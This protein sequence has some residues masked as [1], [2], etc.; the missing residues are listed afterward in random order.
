MRLLKYGAAFILVLVTV[1]AFAWTTG[2][3]ILGQWSDGQWYP[4]RITGMEGADFNVSF[5]D[6]DTAV[7]PASKIRKIDWKV[8]TRV[9][10]N[11]KRGGMYY[12]GTITRMQGES[13]HIS[14]DDGDQEDSTISI[15][16]SN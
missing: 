1:A 12:K 4:A 7:L 13:I 5:D 2:D 6:G 10:C 8:G 14:Y 16:R 9:Q 11:W 3:R 15:C